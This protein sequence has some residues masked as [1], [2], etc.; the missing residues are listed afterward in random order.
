MLFSTDVHCTSVW[1]IFLVR[2]HHF[3]LDRNALFTPGPGEIGSN[4][5]AKFG[6]GGGLAG[7]ILVYVKIVHWEA[8]ALSTQPRPLGFSRPSTWCPHWNECANNL[9]FNASNEAPLSSSTLKHL[10]KRF[11]IY[12]LWGASSKI[13]REFLIGEER[14]VLQWT[15]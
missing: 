4:S 3:N 2:I 11:Q 8:C 15:E 7:C 14:N 5:Y 13:I 12:P 1:T 6:G 10:G 9:S